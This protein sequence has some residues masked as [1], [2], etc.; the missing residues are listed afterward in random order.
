[1][2]DP[3]SPND[4][5]LE[6]LNTTLPRFPLVVPAEKLIGEGAAVPPENTRLPFDTPT[7]K[8]PFPCIVMD[9]PSIV[10]EEL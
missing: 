7:E 1:M 3:F 4:T 9:R 5:P 6:L 2:V 10:P 8:F